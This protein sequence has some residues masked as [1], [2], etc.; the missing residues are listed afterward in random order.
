MR[1]L[2]YVLDQLRQPETVLTEVC[3]QT[4]L[5]A[6]WLWQLKDGR[7]PNPGVRKIQTLYDYFL[8]KNT[9]ATTTQPEKEAA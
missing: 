2:D 9:H 7:I 5:K 6:S 4:G 8:G 3:R 1:M